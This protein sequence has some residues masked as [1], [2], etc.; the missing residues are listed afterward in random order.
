M[1]QPS[2][3]APWAEE[4]RQLFRAGSTSQFVLYGS[5]DDLVPGAPENGQPSFVPLRR[6][7]TEVMFEPFDVVLHY[8]RGRGIRVPKGGDHFHRFLQAFDALTST[9]SCL[10]VRWRP[11]IRLSR[12][13]SAF[14]S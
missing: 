4:I 2:A 14:S 3:L 6:F 10:C 8:D 13:M 7:L 12:L 1:S 5:V 9:L 11:F